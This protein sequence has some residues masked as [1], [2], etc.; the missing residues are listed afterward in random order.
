[1]LLSTSFEERLRGV[2]RLAA[3]GTEEAVKALAGGMTPGSAVRT[4]ARTRLAAVRALALHMKDHEQARR[5]MVSVLNSVRAGVPEGSLDVMAR[6]TAALALAKVGTADALTPLI[7]A[8]IGRGRT[9]EL[10]TA[11]LV[12]FPPSELGPLG[13]SPKTMTAQVITL[14]GEIGDPR[15]LG[16]LRKQRK[17][18]PPHIRW[19]AAVALAKM[20]DGTPARDAEK[21]GKKK[22]KDKK[23]ADPKGRVAG[24]EV[25]MWL[26]S[27][28]A[29]AAIAH[30][31]GD[32]RTRGA[33]LRLAAQSL[34]PA[35]V[36]T[37]KAVVGA[38]VTPGERVRATAILAKIGNDATTPI[39]LA[40]LAKPELAT[41]AAFGLAGSSGDEAS[42][43]LARALSGAAVGPPRRLIMRAALVRY[44]EAGDEISGL[45]ETLELALSSND[46]ADRAVAAFGLA[47]L[48]ERDVSEL[49]RA[50]RPEVVMAA[51]RAALVLGPDA[52]AVFGKE[53]RTAPLEPDA[54][55]VAASVALVS[56]GHGVATERLLEWAEGGSS[57]SPLAAFQLASR[58]SKTFRKRLVR[59]W[60]G[61]DPIVRLH[62]ALGLAHSPES[63]AVALLADA[64]R[65]EPDPRVRRAI[66]RALSLRPEK[67][68]DATLERAAELDPDGEVRGLAAAARKGR[69]FA[70][71][72][73]PNGKEVAWVSLRANSAAEKAAVVSRPGMLV[74]DD[75]LALPVVSA[76]DG[77][78]L[79]PGLGDR[80]EVSI[81]MAVD[82]VD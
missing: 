29:A 82:D 69:K 52:L 7:A 61:T 60:N 65:F 70:L 57:L 39:L 23:K 16:I 11:S 45:A 43:G 37:L 50:K 35:L 40:L 46:A 19:A 26:D 74:R 72:R 2:D 10:A 67:R 17:R 68:R 13:R 33:G 5:T 3:I 54:R 58:D 12:A 44:L 31:L 15:V 30:L 47:V 79:V 25:L 81:V 71:N 41:I 49:A 56:S 6:A 80:H 32:A 28:K 55:T 27:P 59:L 48:G 78:I 77:V 62:V 34:S 14:L 63:D 8:V 51:A 9:G 21:W 22:P 36:P 1:M 76:P 24:A 18:K 53:L 38:K 42:S 73:T 66:I 64:Y 4:D 75:G 20:G